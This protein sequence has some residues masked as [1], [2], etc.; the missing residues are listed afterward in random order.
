MSFATFFV[1]AL[2]ILIK[3][4]PNKNKLRMKQMKPLLWFIFSILLSFIPAYA[5][6]SQ[7]PFQSILTYRRFLCYLTL[8]LLLVVNPTNKEI[9]H[10]LTIFTVIWLVM[11]ILVTFYLQA[12]VEV[13]EGVLFVDEGDILHTLP[14]GMIVCLSFIFSLDHYLN[15]RTTENLIVCIFMFLCVFLLFSRTILVS[16]LAVIVLATISGR[17]IRSKMTG[18]AVS[19]LFFAIFTYLAMDRLGMF[20]E[21]TTS[22][23]GDV[24]Y[25]RN[26][27]LVYMFASQRNIWTILFGN[28]YI[29]GHVSEIVYELQEQGIF[30]SDVGLI[31]MWH[32]F[33][34]LSIIVILFYAIKGLSRDYSFVVRGTAVFILISSVTIGYFAVLECIFWMSLYWFLLE[35]E[36]ES[37]R[38]MREKRKEEEFM[39][40][41]KY[42]S[43]S[44]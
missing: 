26:K 3:A 22:Q 40:R 8:P 37:V 1:I 23:L 35:R 30:H 13:G 2:I 29:S 43:I 44:S 17:T 10:A 5:F 33:G 18:L 19:V 42:R 4:G 7:D 20:I 34:L 16:A 39:S 31:G 15:N 36:D 12:W 28:G 6:Y 25:N 21:E 14:G 11:T 32:Q 38:Q 41:Q 24:E 27:A 9:R